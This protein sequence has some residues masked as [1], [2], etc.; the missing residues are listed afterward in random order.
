MPS[1]IN[2]YCTLRTPTEPNFPHRLNGRRDRTDAELLP[3]LQ[4]FAGYVQAKG[5]K[6]TQTLYH[7]LRHIQRV[8]QHF[9]HGRRG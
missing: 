2:V 3:H 6:M 1:L 8:Q 9:K 5:G 7:V 4:G